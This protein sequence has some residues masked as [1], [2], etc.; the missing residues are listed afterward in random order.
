MGIIGSL[1]HWFTDYMHNRKQR[2]VLPGGTSDWTTISAG[3]QQGAILGPLLYINDIVEDIN[4]FIRLLADDT[5][6]YI[7]VENPF[8][9]AEILNSDIAKYTGGQQNG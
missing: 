8:V 9:S 2:V 4:S 7:I 6:L 1:L 5:S 3:V